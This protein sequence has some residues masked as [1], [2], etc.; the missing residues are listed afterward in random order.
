V[1]DLNLA[2]W[3]GLRFGCAA[4]VLYVNVAYDTSWVREG[5][6]QDLAASANRKSPWLRAI[7]I[8]YSSARFALP[9]RGVTLR[10]LW[11]L[12]SPESQAGL[13]LN[14]LKTMMRAWPVSMFPRSS[15]LC[16]TQG[17]LSLVPSFSTLVEGAAKTWDDFQFDEYCIGGLGEELTHGLA[18]TLQ[19]LLARLPLNEFFLMRRLT[20][21]P[22]SL[23]VAWLRPLDELVARANDE[24]LN[25]RPPLND[26]RERWAS[27]LAVLEDQYQQ[28]SSAG[29]AELVER[30]WTQVEPDSRWG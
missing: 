6:N 29:L 3:L 19:R 24:L 27:T 25:R 1:S 28:A 9:G 4:G 7:E 15:V 16:D 21:Q 10:A 11:P 20:P 18:I 8:H 14:L 12:L 17:Q 23:T 22:P 5:L 30:A 26:A 2:P 13:T